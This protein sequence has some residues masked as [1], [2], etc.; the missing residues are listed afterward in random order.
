VNK[1]REAA[2]T[3]RHDKN[4]EIDWWST[5]QGASWRS[6][7]QLHR[8]RPHRRVTYY[9]TIA[10]GLATCEALD[11]IDEVEVNRLQDLHREAAIL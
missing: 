8:R 11:H 3:R 2:R 10:A 9:S 1:V 5:P 6:A 7:S 4:D